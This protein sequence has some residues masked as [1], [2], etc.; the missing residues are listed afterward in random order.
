MK[1][2]YLDGQ[3]RIFNVISKGTL[4]NQW[5]ARIYI[6]GKRISE[7]AYKRLF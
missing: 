1:P 2:P 6:D 7:A 3:D 5:P 4:Y